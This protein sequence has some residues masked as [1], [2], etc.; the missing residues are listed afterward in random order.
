MYTQFLLGA[1]V[2]ATANEYKSTED[3]YRVGI[4]RLGTTGCQIA[5]LNDAIYQINQV[6]KASSRKEISLFAKGICY[7]TPV[8]VNTLCS[9]LTLEKNPRLKRFFLKINNHTGS[10]CHLAIAVCSVALI[11]LGKRV[12]GLTSLAFVVFGFYQRRALVSHTSGRVMNAAG[13]VLSNVARFKFGENEHKLLAC[14]DLI[15]NFIDQLDRYHKKRAIPAAYEPS[16]M[17]IMEVLQ[18]NGLDNLIVDQTHLQSQNKLPQDV[19]I[20]LIVLQ[21]RFEEII[22]E[23]KKKLIRQKVTDDGHWK[24][25]YSDHSSDADL[26]QHIKLGVERFVH[27]IK[28]RSIRTGNINDYLPLQIKARLIADKLTKEKD[29][30]MVAS[31]LIDIGLTAYYCPAD[32]FDSVNA[33]YYTLYGIDEEATLQGQIYKSLEFSR[34]H[35][36]EQG[37]TNLRENNFFVRI[38]YD[39]EDRHNYN[40]FANILGDHFHLANAEERLEDAP[41]F[42]NIVERKVSGLMYK[43]L[44][45]EFINQYNLEYIGQ[46]AQEAI[47]NRQIKYDFLHQWFMDERI[48]SQK[49]RE[50]RL[51][52]ESEKNYLKRLREDAKVFVENEVFD[53]E[54]GKIKLA[55]IRFLLL[56]HGVLKV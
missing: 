27:G 49:K 56:K 37:L 53:A 16:R 12:Q 38:A 26:Y 45:K 11:S 3:S 22:W 28:N 32:Y 43:P 21:N 2:G 8:I 54:T 42:M 36:F 1:W 20:D 18:G 44:F 52:D 25:N 46:S 17:D 29:L 39:P 19:D 50:I 5:L 23:E 10:C 7:L 13:F 48:E 51:E 24:E 14:A 55:Y 40:T 6:L 31:F 47:T 15:F 9:Y 30:H 33:M 35:L 34:R 41:S 4:H